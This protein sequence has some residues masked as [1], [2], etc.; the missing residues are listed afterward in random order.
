[1]RK[2]PQRADA[3]PVTTNGRRSQLR[4]PKKL[5]NAEDCTPN[6]PRAVGRRRSAANPRILIYGFGPYRQFQDN[7]TARILRR[8]P[9]AKTIRKIVFPVRFSRKQFIRAVDEF[10]P[11][12]ILGTGQCSSGIQL[13]IE[14]RALNKRRSR[15]TDPTRAISISG[16]E[17]LRTNLDYDLGRSAK[18]STNAGNYVCNFS[19]YVILEFLDRERRGTRFGFVHVPYTYDEEKAVRLLT[20][21]VEKF[22][23]SSDYPRKGAKERKF[24]ASREVTRPCCRRR[25]HSSSAFESFQSPMK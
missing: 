7:I 22:Q 8:L 16:A 23:N 25:P 4:A 1:M 19:M 20:R 6:Y 3:R 14:C 2:R 13:R 21:V 24:V 10:E 5:Q 15:K 11:D 9:S 18:K 12:V 17:I